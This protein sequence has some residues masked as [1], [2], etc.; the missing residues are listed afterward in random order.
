MGEASIL[1]NGPVQFDL[2][3]NILSTEGLM[4]IVQ[5]VSEKKLSKDFSILYMNIAPGQGQITPKILKVAKEFDL[6]I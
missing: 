3:V 1:F 4:K 6:A 5:E 2:T